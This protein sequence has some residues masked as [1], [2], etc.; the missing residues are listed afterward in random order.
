MVINSNKGKKYCD[1]TCR[2]FIFLDI[3]LLTVS[4]LLG[5]EEKYVEGKCV[6]QRKYED[7]HTWITRCPNMS[8]SGCIGSGKY[9][10]NAGAWCR[11]SVIPSNLNPVDFEPATITSSVSIGPDGASVNGYITYT[12]S[13]GIVNFTSKKTTEH[14]GYTVA[15]GVI[16][17]IPTSPQVIPC[18]QVLHS[19]LVAKGTGTYKVHGFGALAFGGMLDL[20]IDNTPLF[21]FSPRLLAF[22]LPIYG[23]GVGWANAEGTISFGSLQ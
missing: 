18:K 12:Q 6:P 11:W 17:C 13:G 1:N 2:V 4:Q 10:T 3:V 14:S 22:S 19:K 16:P 9:P 8:Y 5:E 20:Y 7:D 21:S 15:G 23:T